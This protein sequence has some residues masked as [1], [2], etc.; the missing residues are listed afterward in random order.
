MILK[1]QNSC[2]ELEISHSKAVQVS[3]GHSSPFESLHKYY[4]LQGYFC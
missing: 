3:C 1:A 4:L 2:V